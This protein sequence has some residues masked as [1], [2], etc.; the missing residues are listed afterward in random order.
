MCSTVL[1]IQRPAWFK[2]Y[3]CK[4]VNYAQQGLTVHNIFSSVLGLPNVRSTT[5]KL[6][7]KITKSE[8]SEKSLQMQKK[9]KTF[10][11]PTRCDGLCEWP[12]SYLSTFTCWMWSDRKLFL[13]FREKSP[14]GSEATNKQ[15]E[16]IQYKTSVSSPASFKIHLFLA[17]LKKLQGQYKSILK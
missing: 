3:W 2:C 4:Q 8:Q 16:F 5:S 17:N 13:M 15:Q 12:R 7:F 9:K 6:T 11:D 14:A 10:I 1:L